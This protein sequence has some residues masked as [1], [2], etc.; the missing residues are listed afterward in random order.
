MTSESSSPNRAIEGKRL[1]VHDVQLSDANLLLRPMTEEDW[2]VLL[3]WNNDPEVLYYAEGGNVTSRTLEETQGIYRD[4][5]QHA[6]N[7]IAELDGRPIGECWLQE[8]N[9][10]RILS[11][12][13]NTM[14]LRRIDLAIGE[15]TLWGQG[16]GTRIVRALARFAFDECAADAVFGCDIADYNP[17]SRRVFVKNGFVVDQAVAQTPGS[18]AEVVFDMVL[19]RDRYSAALQESGR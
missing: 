3:R 9:L 10:K 4:V 13:P 14:D 17:R 5:S 7:F 1:R 6:F 2:P 12:Y 18:K 19:T 8:M 15:K 16:F 11:R